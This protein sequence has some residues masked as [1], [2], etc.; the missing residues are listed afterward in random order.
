MF[1]TK[2]II[3]YSYL[4]LCQDLKTTKLYLVLGYNSDLESKTLIIISR[5]YLSIYTQPTSL[6]GLYCPPHILLGPWTLLGLL[7]EI[8]AKQVRVQS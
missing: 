1:A 5:H 8:T 3:F 2:L 7:S 4:G 6:R